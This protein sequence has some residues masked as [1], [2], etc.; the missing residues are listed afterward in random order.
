LRYHLGVKSLAPV[1]VLV[2]GCH[3]GAEEY[4]RS[5]FSDPSL[6]TAG[7]NRF[8]CATCHETVA[9]PTQ[10]R[11]G[12]TLYN[13]VSRPS[14]WGGW[15]LTLLDAINQCVAQFMRGAV[16]KPDS[17]EARSLHVY[18]RTLAPDATSPALPLTVVRD[19]VPVPSGD[20]DA[21]RAVYDRSCKNCHGAP[22]TGEGRISA[23]ASRI[24]DETIASFGTGPLDGARPVTIE[25]VRHGKFYGVGGNMPLYSLEAL[26][27]A[28]L[29][30]VLAYLERFGL[31]K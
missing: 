2:A 8:S 21:G 6:S 7:S 27:D 14:F 10:L 15:E 23:Q 24:P 28:D 22:K 1:L 12:Y 25:K 16:L 18:L 3:V 5:L 20:A 11:P 13:A 29:G 31:P 19:I 17:D 26:S 30:A 9:V 4:G